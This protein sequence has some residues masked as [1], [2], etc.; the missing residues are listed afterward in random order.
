MYSRIAE[1][2]A[3]TARARQ[4]AKHGKEGV[5]GSSP[6]LGLQEKSRAKAG[7]CVLG[8]ASETAFR[9]KPIPREELWE[10]AYDD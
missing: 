9:F 8:V 6:L 1:F 3:V 5:N 7:F 10:A 4:P 2:S